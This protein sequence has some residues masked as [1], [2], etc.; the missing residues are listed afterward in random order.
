MSSK[1]FIRKQK[2]QRAKEG[3][4]ENNIEFKGLVKRKEKS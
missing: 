4:K 1:R 3:R 2:Q